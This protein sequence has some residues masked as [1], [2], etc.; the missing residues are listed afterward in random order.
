MVEA[1]RV[2]YKLCE[3]PPVVGMAKSSYEYARNAQAKGETEERAA[4]RE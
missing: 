1:L 2:E 3:I 4:A